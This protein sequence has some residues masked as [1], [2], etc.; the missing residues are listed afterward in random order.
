MQPSSNSQRHFFCVSSWVVTAWVYIRPIFKFTWSN[1]GFP[2]SCVRMRPLQ[3]I[4]AL[5]CR[6]GFE[7]HANMQLT[8]RWLSPWWVRQHVSDIRINSRNPSNRSNR[9][10]Q[11][12]RSD[13]MLEQERFDYAPRNARYPCGNLDHV[14]AFGSSGYV[15]TDFESPVDDP[16]LLQRRPW[17][18][19]RSLSSCGCSSGWSA[20]WNWTMRNG[21][22]TQR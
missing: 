11:Q 12:S 10:P 9:W 22:K 5:R 3:L 18:A 14:T 16:S 2:H 6:K 15:M 8:Y 21:L 13:T 1:P 20:F 19:G 4:K 17:A 7:V